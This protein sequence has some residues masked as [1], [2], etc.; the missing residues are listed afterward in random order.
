MVTLI[1]EKQYGVNYFIHKSILD[2]ID[3]NKDLT[4]CTGLWSVRHMYYFKKHFKDVLFY[5]IKRYKDPEYREEY[6]TDQ[7]KI[8]VNPY[9]VT[10]DLVDFVGKACDRGVITHLVDRLLISTDFFDKISS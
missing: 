6:E 10:N 4:I 2:R 7:H 9:D 1:G 3:L 5:K 8:D